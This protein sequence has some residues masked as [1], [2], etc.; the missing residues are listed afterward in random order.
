MQI[1]TKSPQKSLQKQDQGLWAGP[2]GEARAAS[3]PPAGQAPA[4]T[5]SQPVSRAP[6]ITHSPSLGLWTY[7]RTDPATHSTPTPATTCT[8]PRSPA[9]DSPFWV[10]RSRPGLGQPRLGTG[11]SAKSP[12]TRHGVG[13][14]DSGCGGQ[15]RIPASLAHLHPQPTPSP[16]ASLQQHD[17]R[18][19]EPASV[20][21]RQH[22]IG[23]H[24]GHWCHAASRWRRGLGQFIPGQEPRWGEQSSRDLSPARGFSSSVPHLP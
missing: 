16:K 17:V 4:P 9:S 15:S 11:G 20:V 13:G 21:T 3:P 7:R 23:R 19:P 12:G 22:E 8:R 1:L 18:R 6:A 10:P 24:T 5:P 14:S 2:R